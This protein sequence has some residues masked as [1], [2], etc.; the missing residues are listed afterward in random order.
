MVTSLTKKSGACPCCSGGYS[1]SDLLGLGAETQ[2]YGSIGKNLV[3][4]QDTSI[5]SKVAPDGTVSV[6]FRIANNAQFINPIDPDHCTAS[7]LFRGYR[8]HVTAVTEGGNKVFDETICVATRS[9]S[10]VKTF[11]FSAP[12]QSGSHYVTITA[13]G[14]KSGVESADSPK[15]LTYT[16]TSTAPG[17]SQAPPGSS[18]TCPPGYTLKNG[19]CVPVSPSN[20][21]GSGIPGIGLGG[22][23]GTG[24][25]S[26]VVN[27]PIEAGALGLLSVVAINAFASSAGSKLIP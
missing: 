21:S 3:R 20:S 9:R 15:K 7:N 12:S 16:V 27:H 25:L 2:T 6:S 22:P 10:Q 11:Q 5:T 24:P 19:K 4:I 14:A 18:Q 1:Q 8:L 26:F 13:A 17:G 23:S